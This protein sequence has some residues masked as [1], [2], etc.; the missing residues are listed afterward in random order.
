MK[1]ETN[2][3]ILEKINEN[4]VNYLFMIFGNE[5]LTK[6][7]V[8]GADKTLDE[9]RKWVK[10]IVYHWNKYDFGDFILKDRR[11]S[12]VVG[13]GGLHYKIDGGNVNISYII[14]KRFWKKGLGYE[15]CQA[16]LDYGFRTLGL[17]KVVAEIYPKNRDSIKLI[18]KCKFKF[19]KRIDWNNFERLEYTM[20]KE[21]FDKVNSSL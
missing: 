12:K 19:S 13:I 17:E 16:L 9:T 3:L 8:S 18:E 4:D 5:E 20:N 11:T 10:K 6:Y 2:R 15:T 7:F 21:S 14:D 1:I